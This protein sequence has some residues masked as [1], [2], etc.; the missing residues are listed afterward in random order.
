MLDLHATVIGVEIGAKI[1]DHRARPADRA[2]VER[3]A[4]RYKAGASIRQLMIETGWSY[5]TVHSR[6]SMGAVEG[7]LVMRPR[8]G[9]LKSLRNTG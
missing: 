6:L 2:T 3:I 8:G 5:G 9:V 1:R 4:E 7:L